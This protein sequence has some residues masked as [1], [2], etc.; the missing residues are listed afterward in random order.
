MEYVTSLIPLAEEEICPHLYTLPRHHLTLVVSALAAKK[1][2][3]LEKFI[4]T[5]REEYVNSYR[6]QDGGGWYSGGE[7]IKVDLGHALSS[8]ALT[9]LRGKKQLDAQEIEQLRK[10]LSAQ[11]YRTH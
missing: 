2:V 4:S 7:I 3:K 1:Q 5:I 11:I 6:L 9:F 8:N 10:L